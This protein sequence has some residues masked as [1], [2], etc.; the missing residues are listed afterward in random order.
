VKYGL[1]P[2]SLVI[3]TLKNVM[4]IIEFYLTPLDNKTRIVV[5]T[6]IHTSYW[7]LSIIGHILLILVGVM[8]M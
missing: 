5:I 6:T 3:S 8:T 7:S 2:S 1:P 4:Y